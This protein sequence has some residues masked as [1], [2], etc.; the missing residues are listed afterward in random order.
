M[1]TT[2]PSTATA[3]PVIALHGVTKRYGR[4]TALDNVTLSVGE[5]VTGLLGPNGS[6]KSTMIKSLLGLLSIQVGT[7]EVLGFRL[8]N[9]LRAIR[10]SVG[11]LPED[12]CFIA[13]LSGIESV[14]FMARL[15]G[16]KAV[17]ALRR[18]HEVLDF[19]DVGQER[20]RNVET[21]STGM[22]Q[23]LKFAQA[24]VHDPRLLILDEPTAGLD[25]EQR[26]AML[27]K[28]KT[29][30]IR[31]GKSVVISTHILHDVRA[32][33]EQVIIMAAGQ[34]RLIDSLENLSRPTQQ[35]ITLQVERTD[36][37]RVDEPYPEARRLVELLQ[38]RN[39]DG[40]LRPDGSVWVS[41]VDPHHGRAV[42]EAARDSGVGI[43]QLSS[44]SQLARTNI[45]PSGAGGAEC[46]CM[47]LAIAAGLG[48]RAV[49]GHAG[50]SLP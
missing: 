18:S 45:L 25:P 11:Y 4:R 16:L 38:H 21:Y 28:I 41:G 7:A 23:K 42:W 31:F 50:G 24:I 13:G 17:E 47:M 32:V 27:R 29:L 15:S 34:V 19:S 46:H 36:K 26:V 1:S 10:D 14:Q 8:P 6:G 5:G 33:C 35:G 2:L 44:R 43:R 20:Y 48:P 40:Q 9:Q 22:R 39:L 37:S 12:D 3:Y 30:A 49:A